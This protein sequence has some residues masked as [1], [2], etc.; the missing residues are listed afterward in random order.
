[1][2]IESAAPPVIRSSAGKMELLVPIQFKGNS[3]KL[4][5]DYAW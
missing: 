4:V 5:Q 1:M 3:A 2:R